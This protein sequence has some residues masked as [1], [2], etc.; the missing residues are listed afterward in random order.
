MLVERLADPRQFLD[1][2]ERYLL[3]REAEHNLILG[4]AWRLC[5]EP[6]LYG[7]DPYLAI[8][9]EDGRVV[10][11]AV[12][13]PPHN[14]VLSELEDAETADWFA[15]DA[16]RLF[17]RLPGVLGPV[18]ASLA[19]ARRWEG[20]TGVRGR[21]A[22]SERIYRAGSVAAPADVPGRMRAY[23]PGD[24]RLALAWLEAFVAEATPDAPSVDTVEQLLDRRLSEPAGGLVVWE[25][26][27]A[28]SLA[29]YGGETR[30]GIRIGPVYTPPE[31]RGHGYASALVAGLTRQ[32][33]DGGRRFCFL[34][35]DLANPTANSIY[36][37]LGYR[38]VADD[39][40]WAFE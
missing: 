21:I 8:A 5:A 36:R 27:A 1:G 4:L 38:P 17:E 23:E 3:R 6:R 12:R 30:N 16:Y 26:G 40:Q 34:F 31:Q 7:E 28:V 33:L 11:A 10:G 32:L 2:A 19:F 22:R 20:L 9:S 14:L 25:S 29:G 24:R 39:S 37:R 18:D 35:T 15:V 13:T